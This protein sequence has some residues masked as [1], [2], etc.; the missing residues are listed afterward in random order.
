M[1][2]A[3]DIIPIVTT[4]AILAA[5]LIN[6]L[7]TPPPELRHLP[8]LSVLP[9]LW[10]YITGEVEDA[11]IKRLIIPFANKTDEGVVLV[12]A[13]GRWIVHILDHKVFID[14]KFETRLIGT[15]SRKTYQRTL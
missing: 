11:R 7:L 10:S 14:S 15:R 9:I 12:Y 6:R 13:L 5:L 3:L 8:R 2:V 4:I 1:F